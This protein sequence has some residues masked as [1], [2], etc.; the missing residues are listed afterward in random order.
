MITNINIAM[1]IYKPGTADDWS[2]EFKCKNKVMG[3]NK[4]ITRTLCTL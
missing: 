2:I 3:V 1:T 4:P